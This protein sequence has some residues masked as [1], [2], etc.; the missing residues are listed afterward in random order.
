MLS[1]VSFI[2]KSDALTRLLSGWLKRCTEP[3]LMS[4]MI[5]NP[6]HPL[7][8]SKTWLL[9]ALTPLPYFPLC[10]GC[11]RM[12]NNSLTEVQFTSH[13]LHPFKVYSQWLLVYSRVVHPSPQ[14]ILAHFHYRKKKHCAPYQSPPIQLLPGL[15]NHQSTL[16]LW[17]CLFWT[18]HISGII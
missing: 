4:L 7:S 14:S 2:I 11:V 9:H 6:P 5:I 16:S 10:R 18:F 3:I 12:C 13:T 8:F 1:R 15:Y 17:I